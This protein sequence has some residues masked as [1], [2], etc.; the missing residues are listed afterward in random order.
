MKHMPT[1]AFSSGPMTISRSR[2]ENLPAERLRPEPG[3][4]GQIVGIDDDVMESNRHA[5]SM[6]RDHG[7][8]TRAAFAPLEAEWQESVTAVYDN[9]GGPGAGSALELKKNPYAEPYLVQLDT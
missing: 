4:G 5:A 6:R 3:Q 2:R 7:D 1:G 9:V 8:M